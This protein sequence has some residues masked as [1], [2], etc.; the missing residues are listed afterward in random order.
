M[1]KNAYLSPQEAA[2]LLGVSRGTIYTLC[3]EGKISAVRIGWLWRIPRQA[4]VQE[5]GANGS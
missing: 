1:A 3:R 4:L 5:E 2:D